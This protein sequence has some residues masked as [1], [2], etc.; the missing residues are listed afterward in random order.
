MSNKVF[1]IAITATVIAAS[2]IFILAKSRPADIQ[3]NVNT[4]SLSSSLNSVIVKNLQSS[5]SSSVVVSSS[6]AV[7]SVVETPKAEASPVVESKPV[8]QAPAYVAPQ[9]QVATPAP[10]VGKGSNPNP[11]QDIPNVIKL[12]TDKSIYHQYIKD[13]L[14]CPTKFYQPLNGGYENDGSN[15]YKYYCISQSDIDKCKVTKNKYIDGAV[16]GKYYCSAYDTMPGGPFYSP[17]DFYS[18]YFPNINI[19]NIKDYYTI[20]KFLIPTNSLPSVSFA[21]IPLE[22]F[23]QAD[24]DY[25]AKNFSNK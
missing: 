15:Q 13:Y 19:P 6:V 20:P 2:G 23:T 24:Q 14:A 17:L 18:Q 7:S 10:Q 3:S 21:A 22:S 25:I 16:K 4:S 9:P 5:S 11:V 12:S 8:V 1:L